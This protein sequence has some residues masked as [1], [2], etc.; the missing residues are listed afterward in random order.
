MINLKGEGRIVQHIAASAITSGNPV[1]LGNGV[2]I[3]MQ[4]IANTLTGAVLIEGDVEV[5]KVNAQ[6]W[7]IGEPIFWDASASK[8]TTVGTANT[9]AGRAALPAANPSSTGRII[10]GPVP[11]KATV[12]APLAQTIGGA[13]SQSEVQAIS[14]KVDALILAMKVAGQMDNA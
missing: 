5:N 7:A 9:P 6:V 1:V 2:G 13:Y 12:I 4:D 10:L 3:A 8:F 11:K 14:S